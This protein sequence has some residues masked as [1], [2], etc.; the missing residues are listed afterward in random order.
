MMNQIR[1]SVGCVLAMLL[2]SISVHSADDKTD[3]EAMRKEH[4]Q[5]HKEHDKL[6][7]Q[8][9]TWKIEHRRALA[10]LAKIES[11]IFEHEASLEELAEHCRE[12]ED[13]MVH[14]DEEFTEHE[15]SGNDKDHVKLAQSH[16]QLIEEHAKLLKKAE[17]FEDDHESLVATLRKL[18][19]SLDK[20]K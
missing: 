4:E 9:A 11:A 8:I 14:H 13:H 16:K 18:A 10:N 19:D 1:I 20:K 17:S 6:F 15:K 12:H 5:A 7:K 2:L 3:H